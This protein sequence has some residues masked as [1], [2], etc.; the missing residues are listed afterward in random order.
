MGFK[1][2]FRLIRKIFGNLYFLTFL[3]GFLIASLFY[4]KMEANYETRLFEVIQHSITRSI[5]NDDIQ[6]SIAIKAMHACNSLLSSRAP[7]F[8][9]DE[10]LDGFTVD[11]LH[12]ATVDLMTGYGACGSYSMILARL[13]KDYHFSVRIGQMKANG[14]FAAHNIVETEINGRWVVLDPTYNLY[15]TTPGNQLATFNDIK[16][17]WV[18][19][20]KQVPANYDRDYRYEDVRYTNW[21]KVPILSPVSKFIFGLFLGKKGLDAFC[22]RIHFL[23]T[24]D[25]FFYVFLI[26]FIPVIIFTITRVIKTKLFPTYDTPVTLHNLAK[27]IKRR[28]TGNPLKEVQARK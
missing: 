5:D 27:Y 16:N 26:L 2:P 17:N 11:Y 15:F 18:F 28:F 9:N 3:N 25:V 13:L 4:I 14:I 22:L 24:Y 7:I 8:G 21:G 6:D 19:Y 23:N 12:P 10:A 1:S 20:S